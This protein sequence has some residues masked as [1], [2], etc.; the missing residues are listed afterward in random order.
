MAH[1]KHAVFWGLQA[2]QAATN[3]LFWSKHIFLKTWDKSLSNACGP[4]CLS[5]IA[6]EYRFLGKK[7]ILTGAFPLSPVPRYKV[8][9]LALNL[10]KEKAEYFKYNSICH[11]KEKQ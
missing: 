8:G 3:D 5:P 10:K 4:T 7:S 6:F 1:Q 9:T 2:P 11:L